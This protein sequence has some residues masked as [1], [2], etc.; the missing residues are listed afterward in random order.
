MT[1][2]QVS[3]MFISSKTIY[4]MGQTTQLNTI[5]M[6]V[7]VSQE[8]D[9]NSGLIGPLLI[10]RPGTLKSRVL[11]QPGVQD[12]FLLFTVFDEKKSW[13]LD[14]NI[15]KFCTSPCQAKVDDPWFETNN[16]FAGT[17]QIPLACSML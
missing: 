16:K 10:C 17:S 12:L 6:C 1:L 7:C 11:L 3:I 13:Y 14:Y 5:C 2:A 9:I 8:K 4:V 15:R